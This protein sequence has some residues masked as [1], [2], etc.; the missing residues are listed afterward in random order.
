MP[1]GGEGGF[2]GEAGSGG[3]RGCHDPPASTFCMDDLSGVGTGDFEVKF[4][5]RAGGEAPVY[6]V[7]G[8]RERC[9]HSYFWSARLLYGGL[10]FEL[11]D[12]DQNYTDCYSP[13]PLND[14]EIHRVVVRRTS[15]ILSIVVDCGPPT[16]C[17]AP[18]D[19]SMPMVP[20]GNPTND[21]CIGSGTVPLEGQVR[22]RCVRPL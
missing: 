6:A 14:R 4:T 16:T 5:I 7:L 17:S 18:T 12:N 22:D 11:D 2:A 9:E 20:L 13:V 19:L 21:P 3:E 1:A 10:Y 15:G 8:Q